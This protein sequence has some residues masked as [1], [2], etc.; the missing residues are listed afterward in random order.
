MRYENIVKGI[1]LSR[2]N[3]FIA[4]VLI[5]GIKQ[6]VHVKNT[7]RCKELLIK[8]NEV[9]LQ[10]SH[11][12]LRKTAYDLIA[13]KKG[14]MLINMDSQI[15]NAVAA[16]W[17][18]KGQLFSKEA[19]I[20]REVTFG[21]SRF[22]LFIED[23]NRKAFIEVKGVTLENDGIA[24]FPDAPTLRGVKHINELIKCAQNGFEAYIIFII[25]M[26]G[27]RLFTPNYE[28]HAEFGEALKKAQ[29]NGVN[30]IALDCKVDENSIEADNFINVKI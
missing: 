19:V 11:N 3:R 7:G 6:T 27:V 30:I 10:K 12:P 2:P 16:E 4:E 18:K 22:D 17:L 14:D 24:S 23:K 13:V 26:K 15:P 5:D 8:G 9:W 28:T 1:F 29:E 21:N 20:K 25:Q